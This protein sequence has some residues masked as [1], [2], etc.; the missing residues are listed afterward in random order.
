MEHASKAL[1]QIAAENDVSLAL[2]PIQK[3]LIEPPPGEDDR[4]I[5]FHHT[6]FCQTAL[7][8]RRREERTWR[9][10]NGFV[11]LSVE[12]GSALHPKSQEWV[13]LP[14]PFGPKA[15]LILIHLDTE[16]VRTGKADVELEGSMTAFVKKLLG[17]DP[18]GAELREFKDQ[19][20]AVATSAES[21]RLHRQ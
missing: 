21:A 3:R 18:N 1:K 19:A 20:A 11:A 16:A 9:R 7:P 15:R 5:A 10:S 4:E 13:D 14:L 2:T 17:R 12:A 6:V 8:Y